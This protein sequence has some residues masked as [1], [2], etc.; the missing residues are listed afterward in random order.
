MQN[1]F[2]DLVQEDGSILRKPHDYH[3]RFGQTYK[4]IA[5]ASNDVNTVQVL[6][7]LL[8]TFDTFMTTIV[9]CKAR[10][11]QWSIPKSS[12]MMELKNS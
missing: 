4:P 11:L 6:H 3:V 9:H 12:R 1:I 7:G 2:E 8:R 10:V 5:L